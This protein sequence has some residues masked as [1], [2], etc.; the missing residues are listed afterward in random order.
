MMGCPL[1]ARASRRPELPR[2]F[3]YGPSWKSHGSSSMACCS[4]SSTSMRRA[5][6]PHRAVQPR[7]V[8]HRGASD[9]LRAGQSLAVAPRRRTRTALSAHAGSGQAGRRHAGSNLRRG[10]GHPTSLADLRAECVWR[11]VGHERP[12]VVGATRVRAWLLCARGHPGRSALQSRYAVPSGWRGWHPVER[13][14]ARDRVAGGGSDCLIARPEDADVRGAP[15]GATPSRPTRVKGLHG[16]HPTDL[17]PHD[18]VCLPPDGGWVPC[19][20][21]GCLRR[22]LL[23]GRLHLRDRGRTH[24]FRGRCT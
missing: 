6:V 3:P 18:G 20:I 21:R 4:S 17:Q 14:R 19:A 8:P 2:A 7:A 11:A 13:P 12:A 9:R 1:E 24:G 10:T 22:S 16:R 15:T 5:R 23:I